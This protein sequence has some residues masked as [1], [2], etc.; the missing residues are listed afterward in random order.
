MST[1]KFASDAQDRPWWQTFLFA[2]LRHFLNSLGQGRFKLDVF[3]IRTNG[4]LIRQRVPQ[5]IVV[6][7]SKESII[8]EC[9]QHVLEVA[10]A[11][12]ADL[13]GAV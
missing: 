9:A 13:C 10:I 7:M 11:T 5:I 6:S 3:L 4:S 8:L 1:E 12:E 2:A